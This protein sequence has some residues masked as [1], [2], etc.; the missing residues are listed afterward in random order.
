MK[1][2]PKTTRIWRLTVFDTGL[3]VLTNGRGKYYLVH[4][5]GQLRHT[6]SYECASDAARRE[7]IL[8]QAEKQILT[9]LRWVLT[10]RLTFSRK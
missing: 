5:D 8:L 3:P 7:R 1:T 9:P 4:F 6:E 10:E 2:E